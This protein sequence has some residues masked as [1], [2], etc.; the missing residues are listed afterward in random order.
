MT[1]SVSLILN[2]NAADAIALDD[3]SLTYFLGDDG[4][5]M[6]PVARYDLSSPAQW[7]SSDQG[8]RANTRYFRLILELSG[9]TIADLYQKRARLLSLFSPLNDL[10]L[11]YQIGDDTRQIDCLFSGDLALP[12]AA[13]EGFNQ[14]VTVGLKAPDPTLYDP[15]PRGA[16]FQLGASSHIFTFPVEFP[17]QFGGS[18]VD[19]SYPIT[20]AGTAPAYPHAI[21][22]VGPM[23]NPVLRNELSGDKLDFTGTTI[24]GGD[25]IEVNCLWGAK[26]VTDAAGSDLRGNLTID[27]DLETFAL[28]PPIDGSTERVNSIHFSAIDM[29]ESSRL[30]I[31]YRN[32]YLGI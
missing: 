17:T 11:R 14:I 19:G 23:A 32:R 6:P 1:L 8:F 27:S 2:G 28:E 24:V 26:T 18:T 4:L 13:G 12:T 9:S 31:A 7:G 30:H 25:Y 29:T 15:A 20:Y 10:S 16:T 5:G 22:F 3:G 21:R